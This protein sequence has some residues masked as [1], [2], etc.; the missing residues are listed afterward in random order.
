MLVSL[1]VSLRIVTQLRKILEW[2]WVVA[3]YVPCGVLEDLLEIR[4][5]ISQKSPTNRYGLAPRVPKPR[6]Q[7]GVWPS[8]CG[9]SLPSGR[10]PQCRQRCRAIPSDG[11]HDIWRVEALK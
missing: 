3:E 6:V 11:G 9:S 4:L 2:R 7:R 5:G 8:T 10:V 1:K